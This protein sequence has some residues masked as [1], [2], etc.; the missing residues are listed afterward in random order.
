[1]NPIWGRLSLPQDGIWLKPVPMNTTMT[2]P[3]IPVVAALLLAALTP[4]PH[5]LGAEQPE[6]SAEERQRLTAARR[7]AAEQPEVQ[8]ASEQAKADRAQLRK[9]FLDYKALREKSAASDAAHRRLQEAAMAK[10]DPAAKALA[11]KER[12]AF[13]ARMEKSRADGKAEPSDPEEE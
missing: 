9:L 13:R 8:A 11:D 12:A 10:A 6:L 7:T 2:Y 4:L 3:R 5:A 1:M